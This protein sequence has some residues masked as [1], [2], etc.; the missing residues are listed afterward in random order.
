MRPF[1]KDDNI[2]GFIKENKDLYNLLG[3]SL[4]TTSSTN[5]FMDQI[6]RLNGRYKTEIDILKQNKKGS[7]RL[8][9]QL[10]NIDND[11]SKYEFYS[12]VLNKIL[13]YENTKPKS[14]GGGNKTKTRKPK[15]KNITKKSR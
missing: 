12:T 13:A 3:K 10:Q 8:P 9:I 15:T 4:A 6:N 14:I 1:I 2:I 7:M 11:I 5:S